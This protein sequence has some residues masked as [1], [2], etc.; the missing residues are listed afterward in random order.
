MSHVMVDLETMGNGNRA[1]IIA[2]G[3][4]EFNNYGCTGKEFYAQINL[5]SSVF[6]GLEMDASTVL[7]WL[8]QSDE[9]RSAFIGNQ[10][11]GELHGVLLDFAEWI[12]QFPQVKLWGNGAAFDNTI[13]SAA[14]RTCGIDQPWKF[15]N[16][17]CYRT[18]KALHSSITLKR[19]GTHHNA[20]DDAKYQAD[21]LVKIIKESTGLGIL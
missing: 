5:E 15:W 21:H 18:I 17:R 2:I 6:S 12:C 3:A 14:Y 19:I 13:L 7:W 9:A 4:V 20:L 11:A 8:Q 10:Q 16:D 1:A